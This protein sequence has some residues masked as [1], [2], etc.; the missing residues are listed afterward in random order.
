[1]KIVCFADS[2]AIALLDSIEMPEGD[3]L[4]CAGDFSG[5]GNEN[6]LIVFNKTLG[7]WKYDYKIL[8]PGNHDRFIESNYN[9]SKKLLSNAILLCGEE[10]IINGIKFYGTPWTP[11]FMN[12]SFMLPEE[13]LKEK[14]DRIPENTDVLITHGPPFGILDVNRE[15]EHCG[16]MSLLKR[17]LTIN[18]KL[19]IFGHIHGNPRVYE[20][21]DTKFVNV[22]LLGEDYI[23][24]NK[25]MV[26]EL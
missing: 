3:I 24:N 19:H 1:M 23:E 5:L 26:L 13:R 22:S 2:H 25:P 15:G 14:F 16:S 9:L 20:N 21:K 10:I 7:K 17:V 11:E 4:I 12:W 18:P 8:I 6:D